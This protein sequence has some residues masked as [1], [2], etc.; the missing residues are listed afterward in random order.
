MAMQS[1]NMDVVITVHVHACGDDV[2]PPGCS[3]CGHNYICN[4]AVLPSLHVPSTYDTYAS[5]VAMDA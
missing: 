5:S 2:Q 4:A 3:G 1:Q